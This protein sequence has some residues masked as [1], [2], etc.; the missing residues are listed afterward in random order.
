[1]QSQ[2]IVEVFS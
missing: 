1:L 2:K